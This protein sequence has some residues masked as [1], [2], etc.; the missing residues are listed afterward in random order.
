MEDDLFQLPRRVSEL[1]R[2]ADFIIQ[3]SCNCKFKDRLKPYVAEHGLRERT[4]SC[5]FVS[6]LFFSPRKSLFSLI[7]HKDN[8]SQSP[9]IILSLSQAVLF[10][11]LSADR[12]AGQVVW[13]VQRWLGTAVLSIDR[14]TKRHLATRVPRFHQSDLDRRLLNP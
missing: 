11:G 6:W 4:N 7:A 1:V 8:I 14:W 12:T 9:L 13:R 2:K 3:L 10:W 5:S